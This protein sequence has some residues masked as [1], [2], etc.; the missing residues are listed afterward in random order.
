MT[1]KHKILVVGGFRGKEFGVHGGMARSCELLMESNFKNVFDVIL[2][3]STQRTNPPQ[4]LIYRFWNAFFRFFVFL[5]RCF[6][7]R[8]TALL[9]FYADG[10]SFYEKMLMGC[11]GRLFRLRVFLFP[12]AGKLIER[13]RENRLI[14]NVVKFLSQCGH[15][16]LCQGPE[17]QRFALYELGFP[18]DATYIV[19]NWTAEEVYL[20]IGRDRKFSDENKTFVNIMFMG[21]LE[22][23]KGVR[24]LLESFLSLHAWKDNV[25]LSILGRGSLEHEARHFVSMNKLN[26][27]VEFFGWV[28]EKHDI[29][30]IMRA[31]DIFVLPSWFEG[32]PNAAI[33]A[34]GAGLSTVLTDVGT[35]S[36]FFSNGS[37]ALIIK[38]R[39]KI[40]LTNALKRLSTDKKLRQKLGRNGFKRVSNEFAVEP[41]I[42]TL[43]TAISKEMSNVCGK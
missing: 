10:L 2:V 17:W 24:E 3:D 29:A 27:R 35:V 43:I 40:D 28:Q 6:S 12:R 7:E 41:A 25:K 5:Y 13:S 42:N 32:F 39:S 18:Q 38:P 33:E 21:W 16:F 8:P 9:I 1:I 20:A 36:D 37:E 23:E 11:I 14:L 19:P 31:Q 26:H 22:P 34:M 30:S 15:V 4:H